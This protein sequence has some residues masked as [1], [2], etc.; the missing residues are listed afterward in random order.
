MM[1]PITL[2]EYQLLMINGFF[3]FTPRN[4]ILKD[5]TATHTQLFLFTL[6][7]QTW[8]PI[9]FPELPFYIEYS[10]AFDRH[11]QYGFFIQG[12]N[13]SQAIKIPCY[14]VTF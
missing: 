3:R 7:D 14:Q 2:G 11:N 4:L 8:S 1:K 6:P 5:P 10:I 9:A 12:T 13:P